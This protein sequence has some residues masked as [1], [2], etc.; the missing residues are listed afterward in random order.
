VPQQ[1]FGSDCC[2]LYRAFD[3]RR[4]HIASIKKATVRWLVVGVLLIFC[5]NS[6]R[7]NRTAYFP[8][9]I[10]KGTGLPDAVY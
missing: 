4:C 8:L 5:I 2:H 3:D 6:G 1:A 10:N 7:D 9:T